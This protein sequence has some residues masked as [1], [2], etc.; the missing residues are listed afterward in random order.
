[1]RLRT[2]MDD[3]LQSSSTPAAQRFLENLATEIIDPAAP[4]LSGN[5]GTV[6][7]YLNSRRSVL[8]NNYPSL[9]PGPQPVDPDIKITSVEHNPDSGNQEEEYVRISNNEDTEIDL[10]GWTISGGVEFTMPPG[11]VIERNGDMYICPD[12]R[13]FANRAVSPRGGEFHLAVGPYSGHISNFGETLVLSDA[14]AT[15]V[16]SYSTPV[17]P[18]DAQRYLVVSEIMYHPAAP[19]Q[20]AEF[21]ELMNISDT[22]TLDLE[23]VSFTAGIDYSFPA[24]ASLAPGARTVVGFASFENGSRLN[25]GSDRIKLEDADNSTIREFTYDDEAPWPVAADGAGFSLI[26]INPEGNPDHDDPA[27][28]RSSTTTGGN[29]GSSDA[30]AF[31][32]NPDDDL[33]ADGI[34]ALLEHA[35]G[36]SDTSAAPAPVSVSA[37]G[38]QLVVQVQKNQGA[39]DVQLVLE[40][41]GDLATWIPSPEEMVLVS[42]TNNGDGTATLV[43]ESGIGFLGSTRHQFIRLRAEPIP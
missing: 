25:N 17:D 40:M 23:G 43:Y 32:G 41:S 13:A 33:D 3:L 28:W 10:S 22:V 6:N 7:T 37:S 36:T 11:T 35:L 1:R 24:G 27:N 38:T 20:D 14:D 30:S 31:S 34:P 15:P 19:D 8:F 12:T 26:L 2:L 9:I 18:S 16:D 39:D 42:D 29:P 5:I 21:I 4:P